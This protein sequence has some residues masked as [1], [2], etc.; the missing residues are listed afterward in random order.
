MRADR[1]RTRRGRAI[2]ALACMMLA[3]ALVPALAPGASATPT[4]RHGGVRPVVF[5]HGFSGSGGQFETA[6]RRFASNGYPADRIEVQE[7][8]STFSTITPAQVHAAL[9]ARI[10]ALLARTGADRVDLVG[11]S[12][13][14]SV[15]Q[16]YLNSSPARAARVAH[17][18]N[19]DG[20]A[21]TALP[22]GVPTLAIWGQLNPTGTITGATNVDESD[23]G[24]TETVTSEASFRQMY[25]FFTGRAPRTTRIR[26][27][28]AGRVHLSGRAVLFPTNTGVTAARLDVYRVDPR[29][30]RRLGQW[31]G[32]RP[33]ATYQ[34]AGDGAFGPFRASG[35]AHYEFAVTRGTVTHHFYFQ[36]FVRTDRLI[37][38]LTSEPDQGLDAIAQKSATTTNLIVTRYK[39]WW[40]DQGPRNDTLTANGVS[41][42]DGI[43]PRSKLAIAVFT[44]DANED[45]VSAP[46]VP[47][48][49]LANIP[50]LTGQDTVIRA[51]PASPPNGVVRLESRQRGGRATDVVNVPNWASAGDRVSVQFNDY[52]GSYRR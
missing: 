43:A 41:L 30:G 21:A 9:D 5:V 52:S 42:V 46:G 37:R 28:P 36:P 1:L 15:S 29:T 50:F 3:V 26:P 39:E 34:L 35:A 25:S 51:S 22:G 45:G 33:V 38:L 19:L 20:A 13:G 12:L 18:V 16:G 49:A 8:D 2:A 14:T 6:A 24:H 48:P 10:T 23:Q 31:F 27:E 44:F 11:H 47:V 40:S 7:Y 4:D 32:N 17:Y